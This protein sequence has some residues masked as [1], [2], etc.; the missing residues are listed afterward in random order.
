MGLRYPGR[1]GVLLPR[2]SLI[3]QAS[4]RRLKDR[5]TV[6]ASLI[7]PSTLVLATVQQTAG[8]AMVKAAVPN[9]AQETFTIY[10]SKNA[11]VKTVVAWTLVN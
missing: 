11:T 4:P 10:L 5:G 2:L 3:A 8:G 7:E 9:P 6:S 1:L